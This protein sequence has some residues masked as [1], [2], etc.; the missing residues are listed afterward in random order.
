MQQDPDELEN[1]AGQAPDLARQLDT[2]LCQYFDAIGAGELS[3]NRRTTDDVYS[4]HER[5]QVEEH[6]RDL[7]YL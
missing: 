7:G 6:L 4:D 1:I 3:L 2:Q 5:S